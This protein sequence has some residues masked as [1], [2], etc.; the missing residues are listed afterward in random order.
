MEN[1]FI[2]YRDPI[3]GLI[4]LISIILL[5][6]V[7][8]YL[9]GIFSKNSE[10]ENIEKFIKKF[11]ISNGLDDEHKKILQ[12][13]QVGADTLGFLA[14]TFAKSGDYEK[15]ISVYLIA[16]EKVNSN[17]EKRFI[18]T[19]LGKIY[20]KAGFLGRAE[21]V[22]LESLKLSP[23]NT[24][25]LTHLSV[26]YEKLK[27][28]DRVLEVLDALRELGADTRS[29]TDY[30]KSQ[31]IA[32]NVK[33]PF[34]EKINE[35]LRLE[36]GFKNAPRFA[37]ELCLQHKEPFSNLS[38]FPPLE[39]CVDML[40]DFK[41]AVN[42]EDSEYAAFFGAKGLSKNSQKSKFFEINAL[43]ELKKSNLNA[44][45]A[46]E[47]VCTECKNTIPLFFYRCPICHKLDTSCIIPKITEKRI[48][49][50]QTF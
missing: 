11:D 42:L 36:N 48:E 3:F 23:R 49:I 25:S 38:K 31:I 22:F 19:N 45:L 27:K 16:L 5:V 12:N 50:S 34:S 32:N 1:F 43:R 44:D 10:Q 21:E 39:K 18:L 35:I 9:W 8:S 41:E 4:V 6:A 15:A 30:I 40:N 26:I 37:L 24:E 2:E 46:F 14:L 13:L 28:F 47:F 29:E 33:M 20:F 17:K 7:L